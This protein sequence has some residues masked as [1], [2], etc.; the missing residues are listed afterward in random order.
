[1]RFRQ[2]RIRGLV[3]VAGV[4]AS[5]FGPHLS[6]ACAAQEDSVADA[7]VKV[8]VDVN[9]WAYFA[10]FAQASQVGVDE[11]RVRDVWPGVRF[12]ALPK[13]VHKLLQQPV[14]NIPDL[15]DCLDD[16]RA[17]GI[18][19]VDLLGNSDKETPPL[20][21]HEAA[22]QILFSV[23]PLGDFKPKSER[24]DE[25]LDEFTSHAKLWAKEVAK[26]KPAQWIERWY[27][28][29]SHQQRLDFMV[30]ALE[31]EIGEAF[32]LI[33]QQFIQRAKEPDDY[34]TIELWAWC[35][36]RRHKAAKLLKQVKPAIGPPNQMIEFF[37]E[38][39][40]KDTSLETSIQ[41]WLAGKL[42]YRE[43]AFQISVA[44]D[45]PWRT[46]SMKVER[47]GMHRPVLENQIRTL[48]GAASQTGQLSKRI[49]LMK[50]A[51]SCASDLHEVLERSEPVYPKQ[52][53]P[54]N[55][56][57]MK[58]TCQQLQ[59][60]LDDNRLAFTGRLLESPA[61]I[62]AEIVWEFWA[63]NDQEMDILF[64]GGKRDWRNGVFD[65]L[66]CDRAIRIQAAREILDRKKRLAPEIYP[67]RNAAKV[68][69]SLKGESAAEWRKQLSKLDW[70]QRL[71]LWKEAQRNNEFSQRF[72][73]LKFQFVGWENRTGVENSFKDVWGPS[74]QG[75]N[76]S[77]KNW[78]RLKQW[79]V[80]ETLHKRFWLIVGES[81]SSAPGITLYLL[82][83]DRY[84]TRSFRKKAPNKNPRLRLQLGQFDYQ[85]EFAIENGK[86]KSQSGAGDQE[87]TFEQTLKS[88][89]DPFV[90]PYVRGRPVIFWMVTESDAGN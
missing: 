48:I 83:D 1:M 64:R 40:V 79:L 55:A 9:Q 11:T 43:L 44:I 37:C 54:P 63:P 58:E 72:Q 67:A 61:S 33:E 49:D 74:F 39:L 26:L 59:K 46:H 20:T 5:H 84:Y 24:R 89:T 2:S 35:R 28:A 14:A 18:G 62:A 15:I 30:L 86:L 87:S 50:L 3:L 21:C 90:N 80:S 16:G 88:L 75:V 25:V 27:A 8:K 69:D 71:T 76:L 12:D 22:L 70:E 57:S 13:R 38:A 56:V 6:E 78:E 82:P 66:F 81:H 41:Q 45:M 85:E 7:L 77:V 17:T 36:Q 47:T 29:A 19:R 42:E 52:V 10:R 73:T 60:I 34:F 32:P 31:L 68:I 4:L 51:K 65:E 23:I 53:V